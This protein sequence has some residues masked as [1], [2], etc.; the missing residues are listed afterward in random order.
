M[1]RRPK[2]QRVP[3]TRAGGEWTEAGFW[4]FVRSGLREMSRRWPPRKQ[5]L[6]DAREGYSGPNKR[7]KWSYRCA[8]CG[9]LFQQKEVHVDHIEPVGALSSFDEVGP[10]LQRLLCEADGLRVLCKACHQDRTN[11]KE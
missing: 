9:G 4:G 11:S 1:A 2:T 7:R 5:A 8:G 6:L 3:R 10:F